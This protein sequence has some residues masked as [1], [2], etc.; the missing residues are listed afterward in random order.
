MGTLPPNW[1]GSSPRAPPS[2][3]PNRQAWCT[4]RDRPACYLLGQLRRVSGPTYNGGRELGRG[5]VFAKKEPR[6]KPGQE[7]EV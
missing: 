7:K 6:T 4:Q 3:P 5:L 2:P 1:R